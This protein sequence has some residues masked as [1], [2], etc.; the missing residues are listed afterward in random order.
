MIDTHDSIYNANNVDIDTICQDKPTTR[1]QYLRLGYEPIPCRGKIPVLN[2]W[3][4]VLID[5]DTISSWDLYPHA[6]NTGIRTH[7]VPAIDIDV[8]DTEIAQRIKIAI[9]ELLPTGAPILERTGQAPKVLIPCQCRTPFDKTTTG[10][11]GDGHKVEVLCDGQQFIADGIHPGTGQPYLWK[12]LDLSAVART[13]LPMLDESLAHEIVACAVG[14]M[15]EVGWVKIERKVKTKL[16]GRTTPWAR[17]ALEDECEKVRSAPAGIRND[18]LNRAAFSLGQIV[19][20]GELDRYD[21]EQRLTQAARAL[22]ADDG[23]S[24]VKATIDSGIEAGMKEPRSTP[25]PRKTPDFDNGFKTQTEAAEIFSAKDMNNMT[26]QPIKWVVPGFIA[27]GLTLFCGKPK[28]G[29]SWLLLHAANAVAKGHNTLGD[30]R[31][32]QGDVLYCALEDNKRR[33]K[34]RQ[35]KLFAFENWSERLDFMISLPRLAEGGLTFVESWIKAKPSPRLVI[36]DTLARVRSPNRRDQTTY[37]ADYVAIRGLQDLAGKYGLAIVLV[38]HL[39]KADSDDAFD[40]I[41]GTLGLTG[42]ADATMII[43][44]ESSGT[45]LM[46]QGRDVEETKKAICFCLD[47]CRWTIIGDA[48]EVH[49]TAERSSIIEALR[50][51]GKC[52]TPTQIATTIGGTKSVNVRNLLKKMVPAGLVEKTGYG[53]YKLPSR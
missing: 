45:V 46:V 50:E 53:E 10:V 39:R 11:F 29:K 23:K 1:Q 30:I 28:I 20:G 49:Q 52:M 41:S 7:Y 34:R 9:L 24:S 31:C 44:R 32:E 16:N 51:S 43:R 25:D 4:K 40:T 17:A 6:R 47:S 18:T 33:L 42:A 14:I 12:D 22:V 8:Y 13:Y 2:D 27:E 15:R 21:V 26:F 36:I 35:E 38:H 37:D 19:G 3:Q 5:A 48:D